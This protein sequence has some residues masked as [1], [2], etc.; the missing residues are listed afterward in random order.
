[1]A[2]AYDEDKDTPLWRTP[3]EAAAELE[4]SRE[5]VTATAPAHVIGHL[6]QRLVSSAVTA[7]NAVTHDP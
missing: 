5:V 4:A 6:C 1:M 7:P 2:R 3:A